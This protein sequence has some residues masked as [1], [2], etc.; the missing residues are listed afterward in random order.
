[1]SPTRSTRRR[2]GPR[3]SLLV[4]AA[5]GL[6]AAGCGSDDA[7]TDDP[8]I[9]DPTSNES[10]ANASGS[11]IATHGLFQCWKAWKPS[12]HATGSSAST[13]AVPSG[14]GVA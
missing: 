1:M 5:A 10:V 6:L 13:N 7:A 9:D 11:T 2:P 8:R 4:L 12:A 3:R 14:T